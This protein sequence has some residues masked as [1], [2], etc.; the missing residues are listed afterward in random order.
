MLSLL[1]PFFASAFFLYDTPLWELLFTP[2]VEP[3]APTQSRSARTPRGIADKPRIGRDESMRKN[4]KKRVA[5]K[6]VS[7]KV[8]RVHCHAHQHLSRDYPSFSALGH[9]EY[10]QDVLSRTNV[11]RPVL[12]QKHFDLPTAVSAKN[13]TKESLDQL[14][15]TYI[16]TQQ[17]PSTKEC[18]KNV[19][20]PKLDICNQA[21][22][23]CYEEDRD[24]ILYWKSRVPA[25]GPKDV[26]PVSSSVSVRLEGSNDRELPP[27]DQST[28]EGGLMS[29]SPPSAPFPKFG[30]IKLT[31]SLMSDCVGFR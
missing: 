2:P 13:A 4:Q 12:F 29:P 18:T 10:L 15:R 16:I 26:S 20:K 30:F 27:T 25:I 1:L 11:F 23:H 7:K 6:K 5:G 8:N 31:P 14:A 19:A 21:K 17:D 9:R 24:W 22:N 3:V 28:L